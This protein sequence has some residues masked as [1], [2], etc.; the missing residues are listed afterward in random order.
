MGSR[1]SMDLIRRVLSG[2]WSAT[3]DA[4]RPGELLSLTGHFFHPQSGLHSEGVWHNMSMAFV[5]AKLYSKTQEAQFRELALRTSSSVWNLNFDASAH[6][7]RQRT[8]S[9]FWGTEVQQG[10]KKSAYEPNDDKRV[11]AQSFA[12]IVWSLLARLFPSECTE[13]FR[14]LALHLVDGF[15][16]A[17][18]KR[19]KSSQKR[20]GSFRAVDHALAYCALRLLV[21]KQ[22]PLVFSAQQIAF[23]KDVMRDTRETLLSKF[24]YQRALDNEN[25]SA[26]LAYMFEDPAN[27]ASDNLR[28]LWQES[29]V[30]IS[31]FDVHP[32]F[33]RLFRGIVTDYLQ[34]DTGMLVSEPV[35]KMKTCYGTDLPVYTGDNALFL[36]VA[37]WVMASNGSV[38]VDDAVLATVK[39][40]R[41][42]FDEYVR[43]SAM[44]E[45][46]LIYGSNL[47]KEHGIW[48]N[49][50]FLFG[51]VADAEDFGIL[52]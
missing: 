20:C 8:A 9:G 41:E 21:S 4:N 35:S 42:S 52:S 45:S 1:H 5:Y 37:R 19:W 23:W 32:S 26:V 49:S 30:L 28:F 14:E 24:G 11:G 40:L 33:A 43:S 48:S 34:A 18:D 6:A 25:R 27:Q 47:W 13:Q 2:V 39:K 3:S 22:S 10:F 46:G 51:A 36:M 38:P 12:I 15:W 44:H 16:I 7:F 29:W 17:N 31:M 50:E